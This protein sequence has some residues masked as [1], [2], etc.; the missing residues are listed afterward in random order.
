MDRREINALF[1]DDFI[2]FLNK[3]N[4]LKEFNDGLIKCFYCNKQITQKNIS[5]IFY[6]NGYQFC[7][8]NLDCVN[9]KN[10]EAK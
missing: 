1:E 10:E 8:D 9:A 2:E 3:N 7:C 4:L 6:K 5:I